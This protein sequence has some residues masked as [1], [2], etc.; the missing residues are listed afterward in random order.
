[1]IKEIFITGKIY[2]QIHVYCGILSHKKKKLEKL[3]GRKGRYKIFD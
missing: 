3:R 2:R 1:M